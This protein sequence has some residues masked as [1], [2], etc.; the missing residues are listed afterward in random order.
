MTKNYLEKNL[1]TFGEKYPGLDEE[2]RKKIEDLK[3]EEKFHITEET[4]GDGCKILV[5][6][7]GEHKRY[8][9]GKR[10]CLKPIDRWIDH[11]GEV[12]NGSVFIQIGL[13]NPEYLNRMCDRLPDSTTI[14]VYEPSWELFYNVL[15][16]FDLTDAMKSKKSIVFLVQGLNDDLTEQ[17]LKGV[18]TVER[19]PYLCTTT[20]PNYNYLCHSEM[21][22]FTSELLRICENARISL[23]TNLLFSSV[24]GQ[25]TIRNAKYVVDGYR[26]LDFCGPIPKDIPAIVV[27]AGPSLNKN[28][29]DLKRAKGRAFIIAVDTAIKPL[30]NA[31]IKPDMYA[32]VDALKPVDLIDIEGAEDIPLLTS[33]VASSAV[34]DRHKG[35]KIFFAEGIPLVDIMLSTH[36][37]SFANIPCGGSVA[38]TAFA[39]AYMIGIKKIILVG[40]DLALT[41]N[42]THARG[43]FSDEEIKVDTTN[44]MMVEGNYEDQVPTR[45]DL[46]S[47]RK[48]YNW[49][50]K[51]CLDSG[52]DLH[53]INATE[54]GAKI[55]NTEIMTLNE[56]IDKYCQTEIDIQEC[57]DKVPPIFTEEQKEVCRKYLTDVYKEFDIVSEL[58][59]KL[60]TSYKKLA[61]LCKNKNLDLAAYEKVLKKIKNGT[62]KIEGHY[63]PNVMIKETL[64]LANF[65]LESEQNLIPDDDMCAEGREIA[66]QGILYTRLMKECADLYSDYLK[67]NYPKED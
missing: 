1:K 14:L 6:D 55:E 37:I 45:G 12:Q 33:A 58:A 42:K 2:I 46:D 29:Q 7:D 20:L 11:L 21:K 57:I 64:E 31:G 32:I 16:R 34:L 19:L 54:G 25:N 49:Y 8:L 36:G 27:A 9:G 3:E 13:G 22:N 52:A 40:Q 10:E 38:T 65:I 28:I 30:I 60:Q 41:G 4:S 61:R 67:E 53:V 44:A 39:F 62:K 5:V 48:W 66:R 59:E 24:K 50:I 18:I 17:V 43:T 47:F 26:T 35:K 63:I 56:A 51:G 15:E 23:N